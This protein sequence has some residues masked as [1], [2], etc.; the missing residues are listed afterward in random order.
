MTVASIFN[1]FLI[2][3]CISVNEEIKHVL[4]TPAV[5]IKFNIIFLLGN[6]NRKPC[7]LV[8]CN[9]VLQPYIGEQGTA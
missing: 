7:I 8:S 9:V 2:V 6:A 4:S 1:V 3:V 5:S